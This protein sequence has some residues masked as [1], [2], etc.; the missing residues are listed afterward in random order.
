MST[1]APLDTTPHFG[2]AAAK[3]RSSCD[4]CGTAKVKCDHGHPECGRCVTLRLTCVYGLSRKVG[5]PPRKRPG[6]ELDVAPKTKRIYTPLTAKSRNNRT[7]MG[8]GERQK[9]NEPAQA[10]FLDPFSCG[11]NTPSGINEQSQFTPDLYPSLSL[12]EWLQFDTLGDGLEIPSSSILDPISTFN[13]RTDSHESHSCPRDSYEIFRDLI[14]P[15]PSLHAPESNS[16]TVFAHLD[17]V[18]HFNRKAIDR[19]TRVLK[20]SCAKS[21]H[22]AMVHASIISRILIWYQQAAGWTGSSSSG[23]RPSTSSSPAP[24]PSGTAAGTSTS[25]PP[26]LVQVTGFAVEHVPVSIGTFS[27]E[28]QNVQAN[29]RNQLVLSELKKTANLIDMFMSQDL[30]E[31]SASGVKA[32]PENNTTGV[33]WRAVDY[34]DKNDLAEAL[35]GIHTVLSFVGQAMAGQKNNSQKILIDASIAA[36]VKRF[37]PSEYGSHSKEH[38]PFWAGKREIQEYLEKV[39]EIGKVLEYTLFQ[40]GL[41][42]DYLASPYKTAKYVT[43]LDTFIDFQNRRAI[44]VEGYEDAFMTLT[45]VQDIAGI[46]AQAVD[47]DGEWPKVGGIRGNR[48]TISQILEIGGSFTIDKVKLEDLEAGNLTAS[49]TL[50]ARHPSFTDDQAEQ[51]AAM[52]ETVLIGTLLSSAKGAW[53]VSNAWNQLLPDYEF[54]RIEEFLAKVWEGKP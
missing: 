27:I 13:T 4:S 14:C 38:L 25:S 1:S 42:L 44:V 21:G 23:P 2:L 43:P 35:Q 47:Y 9:A 36:G 32:S 19:L 16:V 24:P 31:S 52:L 17:H 7:V 37:A 8:F 51:L 11:I 15:S 40:P 41:F 53:D 46:V 3:L 33:T 12:E 29:F 45:T 30:G 48:V 28:D 50:G 49:W 39:N 54:T 10:S 20:C 18:L 5:K 34:N 26:T 6:S 22:R